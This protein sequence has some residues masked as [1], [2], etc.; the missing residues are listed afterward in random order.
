M[1]HVPVATRL[2]VEWA[3][4][5][6]GSVRHPRQSLCASAS[7]TTANPVAHIN[8]RLRI[9]AILRGV[10]SDLFK[11]LVIRTLV[12]LRSSG[13][14]V[15]ADERGSLRRSAGFLHVLLGRD[16]DDNG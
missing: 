11:L 6:I 5:E 4:D 16:A 7:A 1:V 9:R 14:M 12:L 13:H 8:A 2:A 3:V 15:R 10:P